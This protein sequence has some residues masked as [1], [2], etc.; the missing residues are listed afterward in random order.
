M[1]L[2]ACRYPNLNL[3]FNASLVNPDKMPS[4]PYRFCK[5]PLMVHT[6][7]QKALEIGTAPSELA[8]WPSTPQERNEEG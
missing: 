3:S 5:T 6:K 1:K 4:Q 2:S 8:T 7:P